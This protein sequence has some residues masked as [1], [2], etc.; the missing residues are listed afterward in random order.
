VLS[1]WTRASTSSP[2]RASGIGRRSNSWDNKL[3]GRTAVSWLLAGLVLTP[4]L[5]GDQHGRCGGIDAVVS[6]L[7]AGYFTVKH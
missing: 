5:F 4:F 3:N 2:A 6:M 7:L 1:G